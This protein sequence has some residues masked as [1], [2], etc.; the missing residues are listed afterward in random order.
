MDIDKDNIVT[1]SFKKGT[2]T[3]KDNTT[4]RV[5]NNNGFGLDNR[6]ALSAMLITIMAGY[7]N[8]EEIKWYFSYLLWCAHLD[9]ETCGRMLKATRAYISSLI[10]FTV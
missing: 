8:V 5:I 2:I 7:D 3:T 6:C 10:K 4:Y 1:W 9:N